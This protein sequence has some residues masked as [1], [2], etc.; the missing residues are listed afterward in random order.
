MKSISLSRR[1]LAMVLIVGWLLYALFNLIVRIPY[2]KLAIQEAWS[3][4]STIEY[5]QDYANGGVLFQERWQDTNGYLKSSLGNRADSQLAVIK[6]DDESLR[7]AG[8]TPYE[9]MAFDEQAL[10]LVQVKLTAENQ[11][12]SFLYLNCL[13][14]QGGEAGAFGHFPL[15]DTRPRADAFLYALTGYGIDSL[16]ARN[17]MVESKLSTTDYQFKTDSRWTIQASFETYLGLLKKLK[18]Q[19]SAIDPDG[20]Y[21][22][23]ENYTEKIYEGSY[24]GN[25]GKTFGLTAVTPENFT[26]ITPSFETEFTL[27]HPGNPP[28]PAD[29]SGDFRTALLDTSW[30]T[31]ENLYQRDYYSTYLNSEY[32][33]RRIENKLNPD[34]EKI[35]IVG[36]AYM[37]PVATFLATAAGQVD[38]MWP[39]TVPHAT[40]LAEYLENNEYDHVIIGMSPSSLYSGSFQFL[41]G[42]EVP[43]VE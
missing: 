18:E 10:Q 2:F 32:S 6:G 28:Q 21:G 23:P 42:I 26:F 20:F 13:G 19:G 11:G 34:G 16:D 12:A 22:N 36:D 9:T 15:A 30:L 4:P 5:L 24:V 39:Y 40:N 41:E 29:K 17:L 1:I 38:L 3:T 31:N 25:M 35:L 37:L 14:Q 43:A 8:Y 33:Y 27:T 7:Y